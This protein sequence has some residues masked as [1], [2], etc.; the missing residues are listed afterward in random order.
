MHLV[1]LANVLIIFIIFQE[2][3]VKLRTLPAALTMVA[4]ILMFVAPVRADLID[5]GTA[6]YNGNNYNLI[7]ESTAPFGP[8]VW[9]DYS[10]G[11]EYYTAQMAWAGSLNNPG[12]L[13]YNL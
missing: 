7:Y 10:N 9:L 6:T 13:T 4:L 12:V 3:N 11:G 2:G 1:M 8:I 5:I